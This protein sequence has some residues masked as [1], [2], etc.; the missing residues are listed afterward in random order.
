[1]TEQTL[2]AYQKAF[3]S[4]EGD[5]VIRDLSQFI[6]GLPLTDR[7][8]AALCLTRVIR[9]KDPALRVTLQQAEAKKGQ[10]HAARKRFTQSTDS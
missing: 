10:K 5:A 9:M 2:L 6:A 8:G 3:N 4:P 7:G 1:M